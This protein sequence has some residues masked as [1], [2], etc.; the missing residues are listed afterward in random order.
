MSIS[1]WRSRKLPRKAGSPQL[2]ETY[3][4]SYGCGY[5]KWLQNLMYSTM[6]SDFCMVRQLPRHFA[7]VSKEPIVLRTSRPNII[8]PL[9]SLLSDSKGLY[10]ALNNELPQNDKKSAVEMPI[11]EEILK[12]ARGRSRWIPHNNNPADGLTKLKGAHMAPLIDLCN[13]GFYWLKTEEAELK[14]RAKQKVDQG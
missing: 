7:K 11:I 14:D 5:V 10:D 4:A 12:R 8:D 9:V 13:T 6:Y 1:N 3:A 2:V